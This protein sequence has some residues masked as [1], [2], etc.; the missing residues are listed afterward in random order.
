MKAG[1]IPYNLKKKRPQN[2]RI[3]NFKITLSQCNFLY[4]ATGLQN[5]YS[6]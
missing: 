5:D 2:T 6:T 1:Q 3:F 4:Q